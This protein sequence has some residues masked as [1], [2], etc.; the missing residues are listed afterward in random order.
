VPRDL[1]DL[2]ANNTA[3]SRGNGGAYVRPTIATR[4]R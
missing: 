4:P 2:K 3:R 1:A